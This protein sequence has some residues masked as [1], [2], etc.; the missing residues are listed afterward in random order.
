MARFSKPFT[1]FLSFIILVVLLIISIISETFFNFITE[2]RMFHFDWRSDY[3]EYFIQLYCICWNKT[4]V[5][6]LF[7]E[8]NI[9]ISFIYFPCGFA[10]FG[11][12]FS[13]PNTIARYLPFPW[14]FFPR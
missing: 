7:I 6:R 11:N 2:I 1:L 12:L 13:V 9:Y 4:P 8:L 3:V 14:T 10:Y 5:K